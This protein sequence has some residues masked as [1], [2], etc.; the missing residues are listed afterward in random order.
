MA[1]AVFLRGVNVGGNR[2]FR[3]AT[4][5]A[6]L[7]DL[8]LVN[9]GAAGTFVVRRRIAPA[10]LRTALARVLPF[11]AEIMI[12]RGEQIQ[13]LIA[14][15]PFAGQRLKKDDVRFVSVLGGRPDVEPILPMEFRDGRRWLVRLIRRQDCFLVGAY[16]RH[17]KTIGF[18]GRIDRVLDVPITTRNWNTMRAVA[19]VL[20]GRDR[21][22]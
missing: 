15:D 20:D 1:L 10:A 18:L 21:T 4:L 17:M 13:A 5:A 19:D 7:P 11:T 12:C 22:A 2:V 8:G 9:I 6:K 14:A 3:P 16:R